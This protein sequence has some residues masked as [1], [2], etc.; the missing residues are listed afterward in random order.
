MNP[1]NAPHRKT[2]VTLKYDA[3]KDEAPRVTAKGKGGVAEKIIELA[4][5]NGIPIKEDPDLTSVLSQIDVGK[6]IP[7]SLYKVVA[8]LL[9]F[10]YQVNKKY[11]GP[12]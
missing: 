4:R 1:A 2:A 10:V 12:S 11:T 6:D 9:T 8:E 3:Q 7:P 5:Q